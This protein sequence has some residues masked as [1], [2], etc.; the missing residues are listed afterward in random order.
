MSSKDPL[1]L[2]REVV[3]SGQP[4]VEANGEYTLGSV[5]VPDS[6]KTRFRRSTVKSRCYIY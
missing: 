5:K 2:I 3:M 1:D 6:T 4:L